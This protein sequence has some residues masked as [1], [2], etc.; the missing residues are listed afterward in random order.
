MDESPSAD[1]QSAKDSGADR[2]LRRHLLAY[3][4]V[5]GALFLINLATAG[6]WWFYWPIFGWGIALTAHWLYIKSVNIDDEWAEERTMDVHLGAYDLGHIKDIEKR[7][8]NVD[9]LE[10]PPSGRRDPTDGRK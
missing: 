1:E 4:V 7:Y 3:V 2:N 9:S 8:E 5:N 10:R 6:A